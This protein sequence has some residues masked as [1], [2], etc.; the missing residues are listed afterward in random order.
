MTPSEVTSKKTV[1]IVEDNPDIANITAR[2]L[3]KSY[4]VLI[5]PSAKKACDTLEEHH[6]DF[7][8]MDMFLGAGDTGVD[9]TKK[10]R[11]T[12]KFRHLPIVA[13]TANAMSGHRLEAIE[14]GM[15]DYIA[16]PYRIKD[17]E[18]MIARWI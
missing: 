2:V 8:L 3:Q 7:I 15:N 18:E 1:L 12:E 9:L 14:A 6:V 4:E 10:L 11:Q 17:L 16:K 13:H 5:A